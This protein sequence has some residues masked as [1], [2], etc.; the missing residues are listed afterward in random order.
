M[1][2]AVG[3]VEAQEIPTTIVLRT[4]GRRLVMLLPIGKMYAVEATSTY[5]VNKA[6]RDESCRSVDVPDG[7]SNDSF[8][9]DQDEF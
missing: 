1:V 2:A 4:R 9:I 3:K 7:K 5:E 8:T 6:H